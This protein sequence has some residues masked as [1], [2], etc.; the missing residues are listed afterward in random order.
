MLISLLVCILHVRTSLVS[1]AYLIE[2]LLV[3]LFKKG[4]NFFLNLFRL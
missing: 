4:I 2:T 3:F 1:E